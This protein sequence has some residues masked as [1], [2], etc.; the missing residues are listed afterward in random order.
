MEPI[1][2][3]GGIVGL[4]T[5]AWVVLYQ[6]IKFARRDII[7]LREANLKCER[8]LNMVVRACQQAG[9]LIPMEVWE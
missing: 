3:A 4:F 1:L 5:A 9:V 7:D 8:R 2:A 6:L